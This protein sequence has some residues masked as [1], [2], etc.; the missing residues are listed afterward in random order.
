MTVYDSRS[1]I[2]ALSPPPLWVCVLLGLVMIGAGVAALGDVVFATVISVKLIGLTAIAAGAF[3]IVHAFWTRGW[4]GFLW[5]TLLGTLYVAF[6]LVLLTE[7][8]SGAR[9]PEWSRV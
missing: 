3:E 1:G 6:G 5:Q 8:A 9:G 2:E 7:P 4:G